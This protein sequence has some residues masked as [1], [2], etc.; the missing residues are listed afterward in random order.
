MF[1]FFGIAQVPQSVS[2]FVLSRHFMKVPPNSRQTLVGIQFARAIAAI[3]VVLYHAGRMLPQYVGNIEF[4]RYF[5]V[6][7]AGVDFFFVL[8]GFVIFY[9]HA[10]DIDRPSRL[11]HYVLRRVTRIFP[12]Y[13]IAFAIALSMLIAKND[14]GLSLSHVVSSFLLLPER[15]GPVLGVSWTLCHEVAFYAAFAM[16]IVSRTI[17]RVLIITWSML[18]TAGL[19]AP[20]ESLVLKFL[21]SSHH[22]E[23]A[24]GSAA[25][26]LSK[27]HPARTAPLMVLC[28]LIAFG[29]LAFLEIELLKPDVDR[30][31][32]MYGSV[33]AWIIYALAVSEQ[34]NRISFPRW[35][36]FLG[37]SSYSLY[38]FHI[39]LLGWIGK[40]MSFLVQPN[41]A[42]N[43]TFFA[44]VA[45]AIGGGC[46]IYYFV[47]RPL[48]KM[49]NDIQ[50]FS[51]A[52]AIVP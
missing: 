4:A 8:S 16:L 36:G 1:Y 14:T 23:F 29:A 43:L 3:M 35:A 34:T 18:V 11:E 38:L 33:S 48:M 28:G 37:A 40:A 49:I 26:Y 5:N 39:F 44:I 24:M 13:W 42:P 19:F 6:G 25:A 10:V 46:L 52:K 45:G 7:Y 50:A 21:E 20:H 9:V 41:V 30:D 2:K 31:R 47:E 15:V 22:I 32:F 12:I 27:R 17:G 51:P